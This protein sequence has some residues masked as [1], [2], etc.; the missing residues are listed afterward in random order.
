MRY[1]IRQSLVVL[2]MY[3]SPIFVCV[4]FNGNSPRILLKGR[5][6]KRSVFPFH[7]ALF[8][9]PP[10]SPFFHTFSFFIYVRIPFLFFPLQQEAEVIGGTK[11]PEPFDV[12]MEHAEEASGLLTPDPPTPRKQPPRSPV[13]SLQS[14]I[15]CTMITIIQR[16]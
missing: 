15:T 1:N 6:T 13:R 10:S 3:Y 9:L 8:C 11:P 2:F 7:C 4:P 12:R 14:S 16:F 5:P